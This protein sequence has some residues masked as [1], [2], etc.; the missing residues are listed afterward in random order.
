MC[1]AI[2]VLVVDDHTLFRRGVLEL[3]REEPGF[4]PVGEAHS[5]PE[6]LQLSQQLKPDVVLLDVHMPSGGGVEAVQALKQIPGIHVL[7]LTISENDED[8]LAAIEAGADG[9]LLKSAEPEELCYAIRQVAA[10]QSVLSPQVTAK[11]MRAAAQSWGQKHRVSLSRRER[12]VLAELAQGA[13]TAEIAATLIIAEST[14]KTHVHHILEKLGA[15]N[16]T[17]AVARAAAIGLLKS[18]S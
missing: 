5:G 6:A 12:E 14:V 4:K 17:E 3:L 9:Y 7:M 8:L 1:E 16:R 15:A 13:T 11:V 10:G 18:N 2:K